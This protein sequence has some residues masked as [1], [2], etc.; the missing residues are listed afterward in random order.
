MRKCRPHAIN[1]LYQTLLAQATQH[2]RLARHVYAL[3]L[4][5]RATRRAMTNSRVLA[6]AAPL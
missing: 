2:R 3:T 1:A 6:P 4:V 5:A